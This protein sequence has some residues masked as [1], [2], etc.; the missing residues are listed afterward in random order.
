MIWNWKS[1]NWRK[2]KQP[3]VPS[4]LLRNYSWK[5]A[6]QASN[7]TENV[8]WKNSQW[9][10]SP[11]T[12]DAAWCS[13]ISKSRYLTKDFQSQNRIPPGLEARFNDEIIL[14]FCC[15]ARL[16]LLQIVWIQRPG[17]N[18]AGWIWAMH[19]ALYARNE[20]SKTLMKTTL[21]MNLAWK[22]PINAA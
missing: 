13:N 18:S 1:Q 4:P 9:N 21:K 8:A 3:K 10:G 16:L 19:G 15:K 12:P 2:E 11:D 17:S 22:R 7:G 14:L 5:P 6:I 20:D